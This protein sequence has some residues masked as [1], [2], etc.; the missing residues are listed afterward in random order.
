MIIVEGPDGSGKDTLI[1]NLGY[2]DVIK[3]KSMRGGVGGTTGYDPVTGGIGD[4]NVGWAGDKP[5][6]EA[7]MQMT[8]MHRHRK[9]AFN[10]FH[11]SEYVYGPLLRQ[12]QELP[13]DQVKELT[14]FFMVRRIPRIICLPPFGV[15]LHNVSQPGRE[16][17]AYQ[18]EGFLDRAWER[19][20]YLALCGAATHVYDYTRDPLPVIE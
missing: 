4:G 16:R 19:F 17:P 12:F 1:A 14:S 3:I 8:L 2:T 7:Y 6:A 11:L 10:R 15:T 9:V 5:A 18:T 13:I 20:R